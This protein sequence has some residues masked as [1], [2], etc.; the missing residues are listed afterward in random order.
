MLKILG[1][2]WL[3]CG[4]IGSLFCITGLICKIVDER[5]SE[6]WW[7]IIGSIGFPLIVFYCQYYIMPSKTRKEL[8]RIERENLLLQKK[9]ELKKLSND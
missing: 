7:G 1:W 3:V 4:T 6:Y 2:F 5:V 8:K 9:I